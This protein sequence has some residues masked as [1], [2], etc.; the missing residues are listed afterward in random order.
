M[1]VASKVF[2]LNY[3]KLLIFVLGHLLMCLCL[4]LIATLGTQFGAWANQVGVCCKLEV[5]KIKTVTS[6]LAVSSFP[7]LELFLLNSNTSFLNEFFFLV[8]IQTCGIG[9][10]S[11]KYNIGI[12]RTLV[13]GIHR[14]SYYKGISTP[15][16]Q[17][18]HRCSYYIVISTTLVQVQYRCRYNIGVGT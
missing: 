18:Q 16:M 11:Y 13:Q 4:N 1:L 10:H 5:P 2:A 15:L 9:T 14:Y 12:S 3:S 17:L 6:F 7:S 8:A